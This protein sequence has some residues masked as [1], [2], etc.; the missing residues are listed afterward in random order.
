MTAT[1]K[2]A[3]E[4]GDVLSNGSTVVL[5]KC[6]MSDHDGDHEHIVL[7]HWGPNWVVWRVRPDG[8]AY[9]GHYF[10]DFD[11]AYADWKQLTKGMK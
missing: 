4:F 3:Y 9:W 7:A 2:K 1:D 8:G 10:K 11:N 6:G 5:S